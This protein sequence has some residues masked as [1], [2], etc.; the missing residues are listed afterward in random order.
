M[1]S[2]VIF[3]G[4]SKEHIIKVSSNDR[5]IAN[6]ETFENNLEFIWILN[7]YPGEIKKHNRNDIISA[8]ST[9]YK[10]IKNDLPLLEYHYKIEETNFKVADKV[11]KLKE[12]EQ[13]YKGKNPKKIMT[14]DGV[15]VEFDDYWFN[16]RPSNTE[17]L[18]R[19]NL[20]ADS[21]EL[22]EEKIKEVSNLI[23][24]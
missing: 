17:A 22:M 24:G 18:L 16:V 15:S 19:V 1:S 23:K 7:Q 6:A 8:A 14:M 4:N 20:E 3:K 10:L 12:I 9:F 13:I 2:Q 5:S 11:S 21:K